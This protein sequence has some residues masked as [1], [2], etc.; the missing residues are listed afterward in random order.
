MKKLYY[1][2]D[3]VCLYLKIIHLKL[4]N[5]LHPLEFDNIDFDIRERIRININKRY[6]SQK[7]KLLKYQN[8][9]INNKNIIKPYNVQG[10]TKYYKRTIN[11]SS[12][13]FSE[14]EINFLDKGLKYCP[15]NNIKNSDFEN[16]CVDVEVAIGDSNKNLKYVCHEFIKNYQSNLGATYN[17]DDNVIISIKK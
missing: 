15:K 13:E 6:F 17:K 8:N 4:T 2:R 7:Q 3:N 11:L 9:N 5:V 14:K 1:I 10:D 16:F 12:V